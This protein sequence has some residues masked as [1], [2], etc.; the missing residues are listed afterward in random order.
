MHEAI[1]T[2]LWQSVH[3]NTIISNQ[4]AVVVKVS[5]CD[6]ERGTNYW[7]NLQYVQS[8]WWAAALTKLSCEKRLRHETTTNV[9]TP[10]DKNAVKSMQRYIKR[11]DNERIFLKHNPINATQESA[12]T[13]N[14]FYAVSQ[15]T[16]LGFDQVK[17]FWQWKGLHDLSNRQNYN[18]CSNRQECK[19]RL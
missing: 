16:N 5:D 17:N 11:C 10:F 8:L 14:V 1:L 9:Q 15:K 2:R 19:K 18:L 7:Y 12:H 4:T 13:R 3:H 6:A